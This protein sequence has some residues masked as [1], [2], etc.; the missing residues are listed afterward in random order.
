MRTLEEVYLS[1]IPPL[2]TRGYLP[3]A[4]TVA[5][6][7]RGQAESHELRSHWRKSA[8]IYLWLF[9]TGRSFSSSAYISQKAA[10]VLV[11]FL[12]S[13][14]MALK[15]SI[16]QD[17]EDSMSKE[18][19]EVKSAIK[20][21]FESCEDDYFSGLMR[22]YSIQGRLE[23]HG[24]LG[25]WDW[26]PLVVA[27][28]YGFGYASDHEYEALHSLQVGFTRLHGHVLRSGSSWETH[29]FNDAGVHERDIL[30]L[31]PLRYAASLSLRSVRPP[32]DFNVRGI[33]QAGADRNARDLAVG[34]HYTIAP[35]AGI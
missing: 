17:L 32:L 15:V 8:S 9:R 25:P 18:L 24:D 20:H 33:L 11:E 10:A 28:D 31:S 27:T 30:D 21:A 19:M 23:G 22:L 5:K 2:S 13:V 29:V 34:H 12:R 4:S 1:I 16:H 26:T 3:D 7:A 14:I 35:R 6:L